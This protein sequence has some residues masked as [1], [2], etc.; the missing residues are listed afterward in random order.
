MRRKGSLL[1]AMALITGLSVAC[2]RSETK[3]NVRKALD[4]SNMQQVGVKVDE[5]ANIVHL[6]GTVESMAD[7]TRAG[8]VANAAVG[9]TGRVLNEVTVRGLNEKTASS[10]DGDIRKALDKSVDADPVLK[11]RDVNFD[12]KNGM[13]AITGHV[14][15]AAEKTR[16]T[17]IARS[18]PG[19]KDVA[20]GLEIEAPK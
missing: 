2:H 10:L 11:Q 6:T 16:V 17:D 1:A 20:N 5:D 18:A 4:Q 12:V 15:S 19:V 3:D 13:V 7:R 14:Q 9:T 8:E